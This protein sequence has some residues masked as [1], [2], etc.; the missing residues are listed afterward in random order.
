M[1]SQATFKL[2][3]MEDPNHIWELFDGVLEKKPTM[4]V[5]H[6]RLMARLMSQ[7]VRQLDVDEYE[8]RVNSGR[9][10]S[11]TRTYFVP[12]VYIVP[13]KLVPLPGD[14]DLTLESLEKPMPFVAEV[15]S[16]STGD[17]DVDRK[18]PSYQAR[19]DL[20]IWRLHPYERTLTA[21]RRRD[22]G[23]YDESIQK[24]GVVHLV[25]LP[26]VSVDLDELFKLS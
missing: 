26:S 16:P 18:F 17:Y 10:N 4:T 6:N 11:G 22:D 23:G 8:V 24:G 3:A 21:W 5:P 14:G 20:E 19:G 13:V 7:L 15:W 1:V 12:D 2:V 9:L 25:G